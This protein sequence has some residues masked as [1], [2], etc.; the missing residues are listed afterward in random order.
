MTRAS[1]FALHGRHALML[2]RDEREV[3]IIRR[4]LGRLGMGISEGDRQLRPTG[5]RA[6]MW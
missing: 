4:Q 5:S 2:V 6:P 3:S 1:P